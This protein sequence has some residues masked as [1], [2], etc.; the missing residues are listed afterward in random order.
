MQSIF[1]FLNIL[2]LNLNF[3]LEYEASD[4]ESACQCRRF[5]GHGFNPGKIN[6]LQYS[7]LENSM[8]GEAWQATVHECA[9]LKMTELLNTHIVDLQYC[10]RFWCSEK[11]FSIYMFFLRLFSY[12]IYHRILS[13]IAGLFSRSLL[14]ICFTYISAFILS[15][16]SHVCLFVTPWTVAHQVPLFM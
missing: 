7:C 9:E 1:I 14:I 12:I 6:P 16:F 10:V 3:I 11:R 13:R 2:F 4:K 5:S 8:D 15:Y